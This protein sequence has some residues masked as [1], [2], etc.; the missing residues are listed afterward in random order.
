MIFRDDETS[1]T[2]EQRW[3][4]RQPIELS[5]GYHFEYR[6]I[7]FVATETEESLLRFTG[8]LAGLASA[9]VVDRRDNM[10][11]ARKGW[12]FSTSAE[13][14]LQAVGSDFDYLRTM[15]RGSFYQPLGPLTLASNARWGNLQPFSGQPP[16]TVLDIFYKAGGAQTVR[17]YKEDALS[18]YTVLDRPVGGTKLLVFN[19]EI[20]FPLFWLLSGVAFADAGNT[21]A[22][23]GGIDL[24]DLAVGV[25][26]R[27]AHPDAAGADPDRRRLPEARQPDRQQRRPVA[28]LDRPDLLKR[29]TLR[30]RAELNRQRASTR[31]ISHPPLAFRRLNLHRRASSLGVR[32]PTFGTYRALPLHAASAR[33]EKI[34][35][36]QFS[37]DTS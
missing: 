8:N 26:V 32:L 27:P 3:R 15:V 1:L 36:W 23:G 24:S 14:G 4:V 19:Q 34:S 25:G 35:I 16:V 10:F 2:I 6:D 18:A 11:D 22:E 5:W 12:L 33:T 28:F 7:N 17:G 21:F 9:I 13:W 31:S 20:R 29:F 37:N 30:R